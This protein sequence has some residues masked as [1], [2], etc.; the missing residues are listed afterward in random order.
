VKQLY[1]KALC[2]FFLLNPILFLR[3]QD[4]V[5]A[6]DTMQLM[7]PNDFRDVY[8]IRD[9]LINS[10]SIQASAATQVNA[11]HFTFGGDVLKGMMALATGIGIGGI[12]N[13]DWYLASI[14]R[15]SNPKLDWIL[16]IYCPGYVEK[17]K[18]RV[19]NNDGSYSVETNYENA[20]LWEKGA[21]GFI[22]EAGDTVGWHYVYRDPRINPALAKWLQPAYQ[23]KQEHASINYREFALLGEFAGKESCILFN[24]SDNRIYLFRGNEP[25]GI[26]QCLKPSMQIIFNKKKHKVVQPYLLVNQKLTAWER[27]DVLRLAMAG[28]RIKRAIEL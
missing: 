3:A 10:I 19:R 26:L 17:Q 16:D 7:Q 4:T 18:S 25:T 5:A 13:V 14:I 28:L 21:I 8:T 1:P 11:V 22:I 20:F 2:L 23:G 6:F 24:S 9:T 27:M 15:T 12:K